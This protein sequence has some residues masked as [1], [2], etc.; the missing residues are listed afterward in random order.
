ML[1]LVTCH[2][3]V[4]LVRGCCSEG[5]T[6]GRSKFGKIG[7]YVERHAKR[8]LRPLFGSIT[9]IDA[10]HILVD[11]LLAVGTLAFKTGPTVRLED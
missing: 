8:R 9:T 2:L 10:I 7:G 6:V 3:L 1:P 11:T 4:F 5:L